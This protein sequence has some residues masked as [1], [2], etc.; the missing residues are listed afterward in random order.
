MRRAYPKLSTITQ[1]DAVGL[2]SLG[3]EAAPA[4][5]LA[6]GEEGSKQLVAVREEGEKGLAAFFEKE[7]G[8]G[9]KVLGEDGLPPMPVSYRD[10]RVVPYQIT[11]E[12]GFGPGG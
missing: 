7:K 9:V 4:A 6:S 1:G 11:A 5:R 3:S 2:L 8:V 12:Q 10:P